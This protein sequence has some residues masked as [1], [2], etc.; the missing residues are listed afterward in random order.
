MVLLNRRRALTLRVAL[1][2]VT[3][4]TPRV[5][6]L[7][8]LDEYEYVR[9]LAWIDDMVET[10]ASAELSLPALFALVDRILAIGRRLSLFSRFAW[11]GVEVDL[12]AGQWRIAHGRVS[13]LLDTPIPADR[14]QL[15][16]VLGIRY[17]YWGVADHKA[18]RERLF[19]LDKLDVAGIRLTA[20]WTDTHTR[21]MREALG[22]IAGAAWMMV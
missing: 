7:P 15:A 2:P 17:Y 12:K 16:H 19:E 3:K 13:S 8:T 18:M 4:T 9:I 11:C 22:A 10:A 14:E 1:T 6:V 20:V 21:L 5:Q